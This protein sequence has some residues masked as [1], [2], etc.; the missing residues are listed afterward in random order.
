MRCGFVKFG[1]NRGPSLVDPL[2]E[3]E[4]EDLCGVMAPRG[5]F[6]C[7]NGSVPGTPTRGDAGVWRDVS[8]GVDL[9]CEGE[10]EEGEGDADTVGEGEF[11]CG[12]DGDMLFC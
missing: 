10:G 5:D 7:A 2:G 1:V 11:S 9:A 12:C 6:I 8:S 4:G 3:G